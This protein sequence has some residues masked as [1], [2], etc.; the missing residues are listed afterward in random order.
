MK[1]FIFCLVVALIT[2]CKMFGDKK[3]SPKSTKVE[4]QTLYTCYADNAPSFGS[5]WVK[6]F[7]CSNT[8][9]IPQT[10]SI[11]AINDSVVRFPIAT[12]IDKGGNIE[13]VGERGSSLI[14]SPE[15]YGKWVEI[16]DQ[17]FTKKV[18]FRCHDIQLDLKWPNPKLLENSDVRDAEK[19]N[20]ESDRIKVCPTG[21]RNVSNNPQI[22]QCGS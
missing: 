22:V 9:F 20:F 5:R 7:S 8:G 19:G 6:G 11:K 2:S 15:N 3:C 1:Q 4:G 10:H 18:Y 17:Q 21:E 14:C 12:C 16:L 13:L